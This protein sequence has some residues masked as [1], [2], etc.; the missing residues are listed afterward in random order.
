MPVMM[1][2]TLSTEPQGSMTNAR[3]H[4]EKQPLMGGQQRCAITY[5]VLK[6]YLTDH[7]HRTGP[8]TRFYFT[9]HVW[10][11]ELHEYMAPCFLS[12]NIPLEV[13]T[14]LVPIGT[15]R[16]IACLHGISAGSRAT[17]TELQQHFKQHKCGQCAGLITV[18]SIEIEQ[19]TEKQPVVRLITN[20]NIEQQSGKE[21][22]VANHIKLDTKKDKN[23]FPP[24]PMTSGKVQK[25]IQSACT[26]MQATCIEESGCAVCGQLTL[27]T[28]LSRLSAM[29][30]HLHVLASPNVSRQERKRT[31]DTIKDLPVVIDEIC[32]RICTY[33]RSHLRNNRMPCFA[34]A[35]G[36]WIGKVPDELSSLRYIEKILVARVRHSCCCVRIATGMRKMKANAVAFR[37]PIP[38]IYDILPPPKEDI[39]EVLAILFTGPCKPTASDFKRTPFLVRRNHVKKA[40]QWLVLN[41]IDYAMISISDSNLAAYPEDTPPVSVEYKEM[42]S[43]KT[44]E[45]VSVFDEEEED[46]TEK[47]DCP[48]TVHGITGEEINIMSSNALKAK[49]MQ[50][51]NSQGKILAV[52]HAECAETIWK[53][54]QLYPQM[55][56]WLFPYGMGGIGSVKKVS[57]KEHKKR[58]LMYHDK[59]FQTDPN[60]PFIAFSH[61]QIKASTTKSFLLAEKHMF[62]DIANRLLNI[63]SK[64]LDSIANRM[65]Q[66]EIVKPTGTEEEQCF[67]LIRDLDHVQGGL[68]GTNTSK[69]WM[70]NEIWSLVNHCGAPFWYITLSPADIKHPVCIYFADTQEKFE[71]TMKP[72]E[73]RLRM[74]CHN[75]VACARF[76]DFLINIFIKDVLAVSEKH[77]GAYG[78]VNAYYGT[79]EQQGRLAL[80]LH[81]AV[82]LKG[83][84]TPQEMRH[85]ILDADSDFRQKL[86]TWVESCHMGEFMTGTQADVLERSKEA[87]QTANYKDPTETMP[88]APPQTCKK[89]HTTDINCN[90]CEELKNW[91]INFTEI[92]DD[93]I[94]KSN[95]H[96]C[97]RGTTKYGNKSNKVMFKGCKD[98]KYKKCK[99]RFPR[100]T[101]KKTEIDQET[102][103]I[104]LKKMEPW[105]NT[106]TPLLSYLMRCNTDVTC[107]WSGTAMKAVLVYITEYITKT[108]LK[109]HVVF[110]TI[111]GIFDKHRDIMGGTLPDKE[112]ARQLMNKMVNL[113]STKLELGA[114]M[115]CMYLLDNP[116]HYTNYTF[117]P[118]YWESFVKEVQSAWDIDNETDEKHKVTIVKCRGK[119]LGMSPVYDYIYRPTETD[120]MCLHE[121]IRCC[122][123][124]TIPATHLLKKHNK[125]Q[126]DIDSC[127][128]NSCTETSQSD[129]NNDFSHQM[130]FVSRTKLPKNT[131]RFNQKHPLYNTHCALVKPINEKIIPNFIGRQLPRSDQGDRE[132]YCLTMLTFFKPW[133]NGLDLKQHTTSWNETF[134]THKFTEQQLQLIKNFNIKYE[135]LD[136]RD[137]YSAQM[138]QQPESSFFAHDEEPREHIDIIDNDGGNETCDLR[139]A[140]YTEPST[141]GVAELR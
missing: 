66:D 84:L 137:D 53:N 33:C 112:K 131:F 138:R 7:A 74:V 134:I 125:N 17:V 36:L 135:C 42:I 60:F 103:S 106:F 126:S 120:Y 85:K 122:T 102:G 117:I 70:R 129:R 110:E 68:K 28:N 57:E 113:L 11:S 111:K 121:W 136:A 2:I 59:R 87:S 30:N 19:Q 54:P 128:D 51:L 58:L 47:G 24:E 13:L 8:H 79:V 45:G 6:P 119:I 92:V 71:P 10:S 127:S 133:R 61:E 4:S 49:A 81:M 43:N 109:T 72:Y 22:V 76:F 95:I 27:S 29:K 105:I 116:D 114:P 104:I 86:V 56:P 5:T 38:K 39:Q 50:H 90:N 18:L 35:H 25:I 20:L 108:G 96:N 34:I 118:F 130:E 12:L 67:Q 97:D 23:P 26:S 69:K 41:H 91:Q 89:K 52:G 65:A 77:S 141:L 48:F 63:N 55:F 73:D 132:H 32:D 31:C 82:W 100:A 1:G 64:V 99:A 115:V 83:N 78:P 44:P 88:Q 101:Y 94:S 124:K 139:S 9:G 46:G 21:P 14:Q 140:E 75:P 93:I 40:L 3:Q 123:R 80:H 37:T 107:I 16:N 98:N 62:S 15:A